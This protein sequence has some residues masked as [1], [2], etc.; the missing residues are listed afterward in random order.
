MQ[1]RPKCRDFEPWWKRGLVHNFS[2][3]NEFY[4]HVKQ[5]GNDL[6]VQH[7]KQHRRKIFPQT[8]KLLIKTTLS[9]QYHRKVLLSSGHLD[10]A[11]FGTQ[12]W[13]P[14]LS[15]F[16]IEDAILEVKMLLL[17]VWILYSKYLLHN[18]DHSQIALSK[19]K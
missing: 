7:D 1:Q 5:L 19:H 9:K 11:D 15:Y 14:Y 12:K 18:F 10:S 6:F 13:N 2:Y 16:M 3:E 8:Q 4:L 17:S